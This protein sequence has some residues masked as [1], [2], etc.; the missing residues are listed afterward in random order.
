MAR[1]AAAPSHVAPGTNQSQRVAKR[2]FLKSLPP[3]FL[4]TGFTENTERNGFLR[5]FVP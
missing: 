3:S 2:V 1:T 5:I 4:Y